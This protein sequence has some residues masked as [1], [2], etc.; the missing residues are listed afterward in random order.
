MGYGSRGL[1]WHRRSVGLLPPRPRALARISLERRWYR[2][3]KRS[4]TEF[5]FRSR[6]LE[7]AGPDSERTI[8]WTDGHRSQ[9]RRRR[10]GVLLLSRQ[11]A[12]TLI[13]EVPLQVPPGALSV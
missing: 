1:Q 5:V 11:H 8:V 13:H 4:P 3:D 9:P 12:Y 2:R 7:R 6:A 10:E